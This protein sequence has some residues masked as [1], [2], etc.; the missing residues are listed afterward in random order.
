MDWFLY[1]NGLRH[2]R[3]KRKKLI[4][5]LNLLMLKVKLDDD[6]LRLPNR[7]PYKHETWITGL[8]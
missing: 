4:N 2:E 3:V 7:R 8:G 5:S 6:L 1:D